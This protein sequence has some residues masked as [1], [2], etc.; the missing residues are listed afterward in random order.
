M[1]GINASLAL[2]GAPPWVPDRSEAYIGV[3]VDDLVTLGA[4]EPYRMFTSRAE[5]RLL[6]RCDNADERLMA[7]GHELG[8]IKTEVMEKLTKSIVSVNS[9][10]NKINK[11]HVCQVD[12]DR[13]SVLGFDCQ[14]WLGSSLGQL[15]KRPGV[16]MDDLT[17]LLSD[18]EPMDERG[19]SRL[20]TRVKYEG[21]IERERR[22]VEKF[23]RL[24]G[25]AI[26]EKLD[27]DAIHGLSSEARERWSY[28]RP[29]NLGQAGRVP[30]V[31]QADLSV[32]MVALDSRR[33]RSQAKEAFDVQP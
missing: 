30:G 20:E 13:L 21:Y 29:V 4:D 7:H 15:L 5:F 25:L 32:L 3:M 8:L 31:R 19:R 18:L 9:N 26:P 27:Y 14:S 22:A 10:Y 11:L 6:L 16:I 17:P 33:R 12:M 24:E 2:E 23:Q 1:A 28:A